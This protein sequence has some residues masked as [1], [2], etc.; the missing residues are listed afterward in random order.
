[1]LDKID[2]LAGMSP[3]ILKDFL[4]PRR[5]LYGTQDW[6]NR[7]G[8]FSDQGQKKKAFEVV[9]AWYGDKAVSYK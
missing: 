2:K 4:S 5:P 3:W 8:L 7:K 9:K 6:Y 1:M